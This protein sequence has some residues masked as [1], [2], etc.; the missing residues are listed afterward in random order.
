MLADLWAFIFDS[1]NQETIEWLGGGL[2]VIVAGLWT[3]FTYFRGNKKPA[4]K[5]PSKPPTFTETRSVRADSGSFATGGDLDVKGP[6]TVHQTQLPKGALV[7][8]VLGL[9]ILGF[10]I[11][12]SGDRMTVQNGNFVGGDMKNSTVDIE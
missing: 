11:W 5:E 9:L 8:A 2:L 1:D 12:N 4:P 6:V 3:A 7:V 10:A